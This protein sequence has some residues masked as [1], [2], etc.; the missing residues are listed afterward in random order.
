MILHE[1]FPITDEVCRPCQ[2]NHFRH[3]NGTVS[4]LTHPLFEKL[5]ELDVAL[6]V[7]RESGRVVSNSSL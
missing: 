1:S 4:S 3:K 2:T 6:A 5:C 7:C